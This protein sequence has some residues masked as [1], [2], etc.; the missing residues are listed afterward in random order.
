MTPVCLAS[1]LLQLVS[2]FTYPIAMLNFKI[3][4][5]NISLCREA[6]SNKMVSESLKKRDKNANT[7][8]MQQHVPTSQAEKGY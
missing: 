8:V 2:F 3:F 7:T 5:T 1:L 6:L 4:L